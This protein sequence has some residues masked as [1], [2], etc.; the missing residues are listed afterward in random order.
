MTGRRMLT[1]NFW[2]GTSDKYRLGDRSHIAVPIFCSDYSCVD[3]YTTGLHTKLKDGEIIL[4]ACASGA[5]TMQAFASSLVL[6][7][8]TIFIQFIITH[9]TACE[10][11]RLN[12]RAR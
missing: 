11:N 1:L 4:E 8:N 12:E 7:T 6:G 3:N 9:I 5:V 10:A 2:Y